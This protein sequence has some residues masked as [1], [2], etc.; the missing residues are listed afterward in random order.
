MVLDDPNR[1]FHTL[2]LGDVAVPVQVS[3]IV[4]VH[5]SVRVRPLLRQAAIVTKKK[6]DQITLNVLISYS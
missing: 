6:E 3:G 5:V 2:F 4:N 1:I